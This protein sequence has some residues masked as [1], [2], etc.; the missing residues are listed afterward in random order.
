MKDPSRMSRKDMQ[1]HKY[2][3][4]LGL[5]RR[6]CGNNFVRPYKNAK[7]EQRQFGFDRRETIDI[8]NGF[9]QWLYERLSMYAETAGKIIDLDQNFIQDGN[10][11]ITYREGIDSIMPL[12]EEYLMLSPLRYDLVLAQRE[13]NRLM[14][15]AIHRWAVIAPCMNW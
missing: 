15:E 14:Q 8:G 6:D 10:R 11:T 5:R 9:M 13:C 12:L 2:L 4:K 7:K 3:E 1:K